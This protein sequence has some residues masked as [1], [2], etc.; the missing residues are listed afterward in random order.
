LQSQSHIFHSILKY[1]KNLAK[2]VQWLQMHLHLLTLTYTFGVVISWDANSCF[3]GKEVRSWLPH[4]KTSL[5]KFLI[6]FSE[7]ERRNESFPFQIKMKS[8]RDEGKMWLGDEFDYKI[9][10]SNEF[11]GAFEL[12]THCVTPPKESGRELTSV[13]SPWGINSTALVGSSPSPW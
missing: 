6:R 2:S 9:L 3:E 4:T 5:V 1:P 8:R 12:R 11:R 7:D 13:P 10:S